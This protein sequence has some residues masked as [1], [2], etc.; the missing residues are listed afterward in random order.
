M[1]KHLLAISIESARLAAAA[2]LSV[3]RELGRAQNKSRRGER[4][5][6]EADQP[7]DPVPAL[8]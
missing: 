5:A 6:A 1:I 2:Q 8:A 4:V 7:R 3:A